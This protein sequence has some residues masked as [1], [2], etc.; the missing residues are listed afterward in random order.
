MFSK[1]DGQTELVET[2]KNPKTGVEISVTKRFKIVKL[3]KYLFLHIKRFSRN[4]FFKE[5]NSTIV[6]FPIKNLDLS[7][8]VGESKAVYD[9]VGN[10]IHN[11]T[12]QTGSYRA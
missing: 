10:I 4:N 12:A 1:Y 3:P 7:E 2:A 8:Y 6:N 5:K 9:L 11:G